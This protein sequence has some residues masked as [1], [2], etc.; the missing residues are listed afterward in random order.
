MIGTV[1]VSCLNKAEKGILTDKVSSPPTHTQ[2]YTQTHTNVCFNNSEAMC[3][4]GTGTESMCVAPVSR[5][6]LGNI[7]M[8]VELLK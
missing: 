1:R 4:G 3:T 6:N 2:K 8:W 5:G 7:Y